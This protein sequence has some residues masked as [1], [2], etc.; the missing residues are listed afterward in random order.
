[1]ADDKTASYEAMDA[2]L[3]GLIA[4]VRAGIVEAGKFSRGSV[5]LRPDIAKQTA[6]V[7]VQYRTHLQVAKRQQEG[8]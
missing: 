5:I 8:K 3:A 6:G 1:M 2:Y 4:E 7:I